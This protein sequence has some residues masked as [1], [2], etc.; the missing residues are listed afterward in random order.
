M[1][2]STCVYD[3]CHLM[4]AYNFLISKSI[5]TSQLNL[6]SLNAK[7]YPVDYLDK[8]ETKSII[9]NL[10]SETNTLKMTIISSSSS[11]YGHWHS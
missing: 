4:F 11:R 2:Q 3:V 1:K 7:V 6:L 9:I 5:W 8:Q 10:C